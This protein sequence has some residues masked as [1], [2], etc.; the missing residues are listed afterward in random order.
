MIIERITMI[1][2]MAKFLKNKPRYTETEIV[3]SPLMSLWR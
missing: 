1:G 2:F 3:F